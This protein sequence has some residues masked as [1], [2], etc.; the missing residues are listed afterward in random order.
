MGREGERGSLGRP[1]QVHKE[2]VPLTILRWLRNGTPIP[3][4]V[5]LMATAEQHPVKIALAALERQQAERTAFLD[6][7]CGSNQELRRA[8]EVLLSEDDDERM[9]GDFLEPPIAGP[10][11][12]LV[13]MWM[14]GNVS[15]ATE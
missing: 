10:A 1:D 3:A 6:H 5:E 14:P 13:D 7:V 8:V 4:T 2:R 9:A 11:A 15:K 12:Q